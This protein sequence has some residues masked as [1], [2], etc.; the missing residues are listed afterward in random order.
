MMLAGVTYGA[1]SD[2]EGLDK[3]YEI[4]EEERQMLLEIVEVNDTDSK[5]L[6]KVYTDNGELKY[7]GQCE[8]GEVLTCPEFNKIR[9]EVE[10]MM[11]LDGIAYYRLN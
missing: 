10:F 3:S 1:I 5:Y 8:Y 11:E 6:F 9:D 2:D 4:S 7:E